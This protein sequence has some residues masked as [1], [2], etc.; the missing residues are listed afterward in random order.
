MK[1]AAD[2]ISRR[3]FLVST[4]AVGGVLALPGCLT[5]GAAR[6]VSPGEKLNIACVGVS[7]MGWADV[8]SLSTENI[9]ALCDVDDRR[10]AKAH[11]TFP[12]ARCF[13]DY[14]VMLEKMAREIDAVSV[15]T[16]DHMHYPIALAAMQLRKH[17]YVQ[18]PLANT[19]ER[20]RKLT[21]AARRYGVV[22]QMG[23]QIHSS[24][25]ARLIREWYQG[26]VLGVV[27][28][29]ECWTDRPGWPQGMTG[30]PAAEP[31]PAGLAWDLW[32]GGATKYKYNK[33]YLP[34]V[35]RGWYAFG[36][37]ALGDMG[38]HLFDL[39][40]CAME[41]PPPSSIIAET[42][43]ISSVAYP[44]SSK[45]TYEFPA[46]GS[47]PPVVLTWSEGGRMP[48]RPPELEPER[49]FGGAMI[50][51]VLRGD[52]ATMLITD[53]SPRIIPE[54]KMR[55]LQSSL[56][57]KTLHRVPGGDH[58]QNFIRACKGMEKPE[59]PFEYSGRLTEIVLAGA[60]AQRLPGRKL[61]YDPGK[62]KFTS[63][64]TEA[65]LLIHSPLPTA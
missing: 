62:M 15:S 45:V 11:E 19:I 28:E 20:A 4:G 38:C 26:G 22:T 40:T 52:K 24:E 36:N 29:V 8:Q 7:G 41:L 35:W 51:A 25:N 9:V 59:A 10:A 23:I 16:P 30:L 14:R 5:A 55:E 2:I 44:A 58:Y 27:R 39:I 54:S 34:S 63:G 17:V 31:V 64:P 6:R 42:S 12:K 60:I 18:K 56:P 46:R 61:T 53:Y 37:G 49:K 33:A 13:K 3:D 57:P 32:Q 47:Q 48:P 65:N 1:R 21:D 50:G 43:G